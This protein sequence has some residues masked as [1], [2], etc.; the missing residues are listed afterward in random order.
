MDS[1]LARTLLD[2]ITE[3]RRNDT[4]VTVAVEDLTDAY[5]TLN[6]AV[7][8]EIDC[9]RREDEDGHIV[10]LVWGWT[11]PGVPNEAADWTLRLSTV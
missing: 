4:T 9:E 1:K 11:A 2:A 5:D 8:E 7:E 3:S 6:A 10:L